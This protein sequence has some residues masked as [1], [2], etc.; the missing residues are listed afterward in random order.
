MMKELSKTV[1]EQSKTMA[2]QTKSNQTA[3]TDLKSQTRAALN[4]VH[5]QEK[6]SA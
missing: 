4:V 1:A 5:T 3:I 6:V 2:E